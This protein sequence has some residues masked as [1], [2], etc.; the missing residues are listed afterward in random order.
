MAEEAE[1]PKYPTNVY[2]QY[3]PPS[4]C[5]NNLACCIPATIPTPS[6]ATVSGTYPSLTYC[7]GQCEWN[8]PNPVAPTPPRDIVPKEITESKK[9]RKLL[10]QWRKNNL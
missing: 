1:E 5:G 2:D 4:V 9:L 8:D 7:Q 10:K 3:T 6:N